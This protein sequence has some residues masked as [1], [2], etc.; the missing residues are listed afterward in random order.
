MTVLRPVKFSTR[1]SRPVTSKCV[2]FC[3]KLS[4]LRFLNN[5]T[6]IQ[7]LLLECFQKHKIFPYDVII[8][9]I[10]F[11]SKATTF[12]SSYRPHPKDGESDVFSLF[13][14]LVPGSFQGLWSQVLFVDSP[15][16]ARVYSSPGRGVL[17][18][19][20]GGTPARIGV[21]PVGDGVPPH[22]AKT[23]I[24]PSARNG[25]PTSGQVTLRVVCLVRFLAEGFSCFTNKS[26]PA[27][28]PP[29]CGSNRDELCAYFVD[30]RYADWTDFCESYYTCI[31]RVYFGHNPC[32]P[33]LYSKPKMKL[34]LQIEN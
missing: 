21:P 20:L 12:Y 27:N 31:D 13:T 15:V 30:G 34:S 10:K 5:W 33:G 11:L 2:Y 3:N 23:G 24:P 4:R 22:L 8:I 25:V 9:S 28:T 1:I 16:L 7:R 32:S 29:P 17:Q 14:T 18:S 19:S 6:I 26:S